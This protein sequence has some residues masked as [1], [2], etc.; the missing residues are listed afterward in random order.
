MIA[1]NALAGL[2]AF[3]FVGSITPGPNNIMLTPSGL[4]FG[5]LRTIPHLFGIFAGFSL[6]LLASGL[7]VG[8]V[9]AAVPAAGTALKVAGAL[10]ML[11][12]AWR[13]AT[14]GSPGEG[15][16]TGG[17]P[18]TFWQA[19]AFQWVNPKAWVIALAAMA[20]YVRPGHLVA[21]VLVVTAVFALVNLPSVSTWAGFGHLLREFLREPGRVRAFNIVMALLLV[22]SIV[23]MVL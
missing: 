9:F 7:G 11:W 3:A 16:R 2:A 6:L 12:L 13:I 22:A 5:F 23:P 4:N 8:A 19:F 21:D 10:Y 20:L 14:A 18:M 15:G 17:R 1:A